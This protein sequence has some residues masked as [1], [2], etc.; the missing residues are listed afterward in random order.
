M[1]PLIV[2]LAL[3]LVG[4]TMYVIKTLLDI[5]SLMILLKKDKELLKPNELDKKYQF[6]KGL[7]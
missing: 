4:L 7:Y 3:V 5:S 2:L 6:I 1:N